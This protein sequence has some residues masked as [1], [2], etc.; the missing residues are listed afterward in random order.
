MSRRI[1]SVSVRRL[2]PVAAAVL[3]STAASAVDVTVVPFDGSPI[4]IGAGARALGM[5]GAFTAIADDATA[6]TWNPAG[7]AQLER[8]ELS[9][10]GGYYSRSTHSDHG[11][12]T[13][14]ALALDHASVIVPFFVLGTQQTVGLAWQRQFDFTRAT[15]S[16]Q[17]F[18]DVGPTLTTQGFS[19]NAVDNDGAWSSWSLSY[20]A[21]V[22]SV[23]SL[24]ATVLVWDDDLTRMSH[25]DR[26]TA[27]SGRLTTI[28]VGPPA[29]ILTD[30]T[31]TAEQHQR[32]TVDNGVSAVLG[33]LWH[34]THDWTLA[35]T[36]KPQYDLHLSIAKSDRREF[37]DASSGAVTSSTATSSRRGATYTYPTSATVATA[38]RPND[39]H[40]I[41]L[42]VTWTD[43][44]ALR[45][46]DGTSVTSPISPFVPPGEF[47][48]GY[49]LRLGYEHV[50]LLP[51]LVVVPRFGLLY[52]GLPGVTAAPDASRPD[53]V[54]ATVDQFYGATAGLSVFQRS[55]LYDAAVQM[56]YGD[57]VGAG[58]DAPFDDTARVL[59]IT[60]RA[61]ITWHF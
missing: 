25:N 6:N 32:I 17:V 36:V 7:M 11:G 30:E 22:V 60:A 21:D 16:R 15:G 9:I 10:N 61:G 37:R 18:Q 23:L 26:D 3:V 28:S 47:D 46:D 59:G 51:R 12:E 2:A 20:A 19:D 33:A 49:A 44:S 1:S 52:E 13:Q 43:W 4:P 45:L 31:F 54:N 35:A 42:D 5:G 48:D 53:L 50:W 38:W 24:G 40:T 57:R 56:R 34:V 55:I 39:R 29:T 27:S 58:V 41:A 8:P 14:G